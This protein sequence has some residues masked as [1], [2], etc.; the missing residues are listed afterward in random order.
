[1]LFC[2]R[3]LHLHF[4]GHPVEATRTGYRYPLPSLHQPELPRE[5]DQEDKFDYNKITLSAVRACS[6]DHLLGPMSEAEV[7]SYCWRVER[8]LKEA[9]GVEEAS[10]SPDQLVDLRL[11]TSQLKLDLLQWRV[12]KMYQKDPA[13]YL[14]LNSILYLLPTWGA[15]M[16]ADAPSS[17]PSTPSSTSSDHPGVVG[18]S[19]R[20]ILLAL[21]SRLRGVP[22]ALVQACRNLT[23]PVTP[24]VETAL[25]VS[26]P[27]AHF[28]VEA[29]PPLCDTLISH[30]SKEEAEELAPIV[31][32]VKSAAKIASECVVTYEKFLRD[33]LLP[34]SAPLVGVGKETYEEIL[35]HGHFIGSSEELLALGEEHFARVREDLESLAAEI[36]PSKSWQQITEEMIQPMHPSAPDLLQA[37]MSEIER[38]RDHMT[39]HDLV[40]GLPEGERVVGFLTPAFL[41]PFSPFGDYLN[42]SPF[43]GM[44]GV[45]R[46]AGTAALRLR[47]GH[48][49]LH[50]VEAKKL[51]KSEEQ[52]LL[53]G[54]DY[55]WIRVV[56][57][58][59]SYPGH[60]VQALHAQEHP[61]VLR[62]YHESTLFY[63]G[64][65]L[66]TEQLA[67]ETGFFGRDIAYQREGSGETEV[68]P[69]KL[70]VKL[71]R[72]TQ[73][74]LQLWRAARIILDVKLNMGELTFE[75]CQEFL[76]K[77]VMFNAGA[78]R[79]EVF[80]YVSRPTYASCYVAGFL[81][82]MKL[83][84]EV[85][86][87]AEREGHTF[88]LREFHDSLLSKGCIPFEL[89]A[90]LLQ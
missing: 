32:E 29:L 39:S 1:M 7:R 31:A 16:E 20:V 56:C 81:M 74:R 72:L 4:E 9:E 46:S 77:E 8:L 53:R 65:G 89:L 36:D 24:F 30:S 57:P 11:I 76:H 22:G 63:E 50:S 42:P 26:P 75:A 68:L 86:E 2:C 35:R 48:L 34:R 49:M 67:Y 15:E 17:S 43:A 66:Y 13:F 12:V 85:R 54:H 47:V 84:E 73:L 41:L 61:R 59:E 60:H 79:G 21:L 58:H 78:S 14:P 5:T 90:I 27:F 44:G 80:M 52:K 83:R 88:K 82:I 28:L 64:W 10:L 3:Y 37:Y 6:Y 62:R 71:T 70:G 38:C 25:D 51:P 55:T 40:S 19:V 23:Q 33:E 18:M 87:R 69:A 45:A